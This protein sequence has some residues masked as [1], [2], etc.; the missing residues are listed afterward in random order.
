[1]ESGPVALKG[2]SSLRNLCIPFQFTTVEG[3]SGYGLVPLSVSEVV[4]SLVKTDWN[5][6]W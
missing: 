2:F 1:M 6:V 4:S 3:I 5:W